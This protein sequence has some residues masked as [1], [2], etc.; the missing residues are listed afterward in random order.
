M[1]RL[2]L[3]LITV[4][5]LSVEGLSFA[6][7]S[8]LAPITDQNARDLLQL[9]P[10]GRGNIKALRWSPDGRWLAAQTPIGIWLIDSID[11]NRDPILL[12]VL[13][14]PQAFTFDAHTSLIAVAGCYGIVQETVQQE[15]VICAESQ[16]SVWQL[17]ALKDSSI[18]LYTID[19]GQTNIN[20]LEIAPEPFQNAPLIAAI[21]DTGIIQLSNGTRSWLLDFRLSN[22]R[23]IVFSP[24]SQ[25]IAILGPSASNGSIRTQVLVIDTETY[26]HGGMRTEIAQLKLPEL[27]DLIDLAFS[28]DG[29]QLTGIGRGGLSHWDLTQRGQNPV[30]ESYVSLDVFKSLLPTGVSPD[31][32]YGYTGRNGERRLWLAVTQMPITDSS[33]SNSENANTT[34]TPP[35]AGSSIL[36]SADDFDFV[37]FSPTSRYLLL[38]SSPHLPYDD[39]S[40]IP[41]PGILRLYE[42]KTGKV[43][44]ELS[45]A[46]IISKAAFSANDGKLAYVDP[47]H[48]LHLYDITANHE[49]RT[50]I[51]FA[52]E[53]KGLVVRPDGTLIYSTCDTRIPAGEG[54]LCNKT[55]TYIG[56]LALTDISFTTRAVSPDGQLLIDSNLGLHDAHTGELLNQIKPVSYGIWQPDFSPDGIRL[57]VGDYGKP[58][59]IVTLANLDAAPLILEMP[60]N[61]YG[62]PVGTSAVK[63]SPDGRLIATVNDDGSARLWDA[64]TGNLL[65]TLHSP[66]AEQSDRLT[67]GNG[68]VFSPD[69][70]QVAFGS[71]YVSLAVAGSECDDTRVYVYDV[72]TALKQHEMQSDQADLILTGTSDYTFRLIFSPDGSLIAG[73]SAPTGWGGNPIHQL[74]LWSAHTGQ[75]LKTLTA[76]GTTDIAFSPDGTI[77]YSNSDDGVV[78]RWGVNTLR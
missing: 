6:Q 46:S 30:Y 42:I 23:R 5:L 12:R 8:T 63:F 60:P 13:D 43:T 7:D 50:T 45:P 19:N 56:G 34:P 62:D 67:S 74:N 35:P 10:I 11:S 77:L 3:S 39:N 71:C 4:L 58:P 53:T 44:L 52:Q 54:S 51:G 33:S 17:D 65:A 72:A 68:I 36:L 59:F 61:D 28:E 24:D 1:K 2:L 66:I 55:T 20:R 49:I 29:Q 48:N 26:A 15:S 75:L 47:N 21:K 22:V 41:V 70:S 73:S 9:E 76:L 64:T 57:G 40:S 38:G 16:T 27:L 69:G 25:Q 37:G 32:H 78:Y 14:T 31:F 18:P